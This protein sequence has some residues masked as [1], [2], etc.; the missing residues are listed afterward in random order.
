MKDSPKVGA[1]GTIGTFLYGSVLHLDKAT[2]DEITFWL[3]TAAFIISLVVG[4]L[5][6]WISIKKIRRDG[7]F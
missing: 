4:I 3:Q 6:I 2:Q 5:T 1:V 7:R